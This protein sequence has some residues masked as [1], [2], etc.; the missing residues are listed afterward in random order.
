LRPTWVLQIK[1]T[2]PERSDE[3][4][5]CHLV[6]LPVLEGSALPWRLTTLSLTFSIQS[7]DPAEIAEVAAFLASLRQLYDRSDRGR[8]RRPNRDLAVVEGGTDMRLSS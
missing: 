1:A 5:E 7:T 3:W 4:S 8:R 2:S 6:N